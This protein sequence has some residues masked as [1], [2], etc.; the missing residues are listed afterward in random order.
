MM[1]TAEAPIKL[2]AFSE[3]KSLS[4]QMMYVAFRISEAIS[5][6]FQKSVR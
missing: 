2:I 6:K 5:I 3:T 4:S 1:E